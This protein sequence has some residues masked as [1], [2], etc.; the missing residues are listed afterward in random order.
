MS[1]GMSGAHSPQQPKYNFEPCNMKRCL[2]CPLIKSAKLQ[3]TSTITEHTYDVVNDCNDKN[4]TCNSNNII[5]LMTCKMCKV[6]YVVRPN[7]SF[8]FA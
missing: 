6:Q 8:V 5:Y 7:K 2:S 3:F 1:K 4:I